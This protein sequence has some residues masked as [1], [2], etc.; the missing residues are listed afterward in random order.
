MR[1][2]KRW[3]CQIRGFFFCVFF[4]AMHDMDVY[5]IAGQWQSLRLSLTSKV[6]QCRLSLEVSTLMV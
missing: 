3:E 4:L 5:F 6:F 2:G 1:W